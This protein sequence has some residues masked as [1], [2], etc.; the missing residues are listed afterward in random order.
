[1]LI[2]PALLEKTAQ[3]LEKKLRLVRNSFQ[4][5]HIDIADGFFVQNK[6]IQI[7]DIYHTKRALE[8]FNLDLHLMVENPEDYI[9]QA[10]E[11]AQKGGIKIYRVFVHYK[12]LPDLATLLKTSKLK[13]GLAID[14]DDEI[15]TVFQIYPPERLDSILLMSVNPGF[16]GSAFIPFTI[17]NIALIRSKR[18]YGE[19]L[20]DGGIND[21]TIQY[22]KE[23][24]DEISALC[25]GSFLMKS[26]SAEKTKEKANLLL[27]SLD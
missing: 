24:K 12:T 8:D 9:R 15:D 23:Y 1:M 4:H 17:Q 10:E 21:K 19:I 18:F 20:L 3:S 13:I 27:R 7:K 2:I 11:I 22:I 26:N 25:V 16:Q 5:L 14:P 6:T